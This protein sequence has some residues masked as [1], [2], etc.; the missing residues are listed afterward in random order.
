M[1]RL[2]EGSSWSLPLALACIVAALALSLEPLH[3]FLPA[4]PSLRAVLPWLNA[5]LLALAALLMAVHLLASQWRLR[6]LFAALGRFASGETDVR[7]GWLGSE[8]I[9]RLGM[10]FDYMVARMEHERSYLAEGEER[11]NFALRGSS[12]GIWDW[13]MDRSWTY[14]SPRWKTLLG[15]LENEPIP[16]TEEWL[17]RVHVDDLAAVMERFNA[18]L[19]GESDFFESEHRVRR[20]DGS[21]LWVLE[22]ALALRNGEGAPYRVVGALID[23]TRRRQAEASLR[24]SER[25]YRTVLEMSPNGLAFADGEGQ[26]TYLN[27]AF[28]SITGIPAEAAQRRPLG[29]LEQKLGALCAKD[30]PYRPLADADGRLADREDRLHLAQP[31]PRIIERIARSLLDETG[32]SQ[33][34]ILFLRDITREAEIERMKS[35]FLST[36]AHEL[37]TPL[38]SIFGFAELLLKQEFDANTRRELLE[39]IHRQAGV[40]ADLINELLDLARIEARGK[41]SLDVRRQPLLPLIHAAL[42]AQYFPPQ[43][44][45]LETDLPTV[46][47]QVEVDAG[48]FHQALLNVLGNAVKYSPEGGVIRV[49]SRVSHRAQ[50]DAIGICVRD[51]GCGMSPEQQTRAFERFWRADNSGS[52]PGTGLGLSLV[53]EIMTLFGGEATIE[54]APGEGTE[55]ALWLPLAAGERAGEDAG[56]NTEEDAGEDA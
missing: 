36:A 20:K 18:H 42:E 29:E 11:L 7:L 52:I 1:I 55:V 49:S 8:L 16:A 2:R 12:A 38:A 32:G 33:G 5:A 27:P 43:T 4:A 54:S 23:I 51:P 48:K 10:Q 35:E 34:S 21:Y 56:E 13:R 37:R 44:H 24:R 50:G 31:V 40:L 9:V 39:I 41:A 14:Y 6:R 22:R 30:A 19:R 15:F 46:L 25:E 28:V 45:A 53:Q 3:P 26:V 47:L 17:K